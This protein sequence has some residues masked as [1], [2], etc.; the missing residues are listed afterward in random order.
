MGIVLGVGVRGKSAVEREPMVVQQVW[1]WWF[2]TADLPF[3]HPTHRGVYCRFNS[4]RTSPNHP[5][6]Q[7]PLR[8]L[9]FISLRPSMDAAE[10][11]KLLEETH[12]ATLALMVCCL[13]AAGCVH[14]V[15]I[16]EHS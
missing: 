9:S 3:L 7:P 12:K 6:A 11:R 10:L 5:R 15:F 8:P 16:I 13:S 4:K 14:I 2:L 1:E